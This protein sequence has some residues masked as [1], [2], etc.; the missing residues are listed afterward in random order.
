MTSKSRALSRRAVLAG[1]V[2]P[3]A[4]VSLPSPVAAQAQSQAAPL[5]ERDRADIARVE[6][7]LNRLTTLRAR[8]LQIAQ[9][10]AT[11]EGTAWIWRPGRMR[12]EYDPPE[13]LLLVA[14]HGQFLLYDR[15]LRQPSTVPVSQ[16][17]LAFLLR[18]NLRLSGDITVTRVERGGGFLRVTLYRTA[19]P[20][21]GRLTLVFQDDPV[22]LRQWAVVDAQGHVTRVSLSRIETGVRIAP[23]IFEF[24]DPRFFETEPQR[25][26]PGGG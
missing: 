17:P 8:F 24:N 7:Y 19:A 1:A 14:S 25:G 16:T 15:E 11:A 26:P 4:A 13:P 9:N 23:R 20:A 21:E 10:G 18:E 6:A 5:S 12:F 22:E 3:A 2:L